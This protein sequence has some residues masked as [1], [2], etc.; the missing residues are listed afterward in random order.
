MK[1][2]TE[3]K[4]DSP[5]GNEKYGESLEELG[6]LDWA[7]QGIDKSKGKSRIDDMDDEANE[8]E[9]DDNSPRLHVRQGVP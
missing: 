9:K 2:T 1:K 8:M 5:G 4:E 7:L 3:N 6:G